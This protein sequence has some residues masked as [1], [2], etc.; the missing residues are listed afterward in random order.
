[1]E[2][3]ELEEQ[4]ILRLPLSEA[5]TIRETLRTKPKK[6]KKLLKIDLDVSRAA[7][8]VIVGRSKLYAYLKKFPTIIESYKTNIVGDKTNLYKTAD[9]SYML[10]CLAEPTKNFKTDLLHGYAPPL[11][12]VKKRRFRK[13]LVNPEMTEATELTTK[14]LYYLLNTDLEAMSTKFELIDDSNQC[15][16][17]RFE[18]CQIEKMLFRRVSTTD[19]DFEIEIPD[20][21]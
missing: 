10:E 21:H 6:I 5:A 9:V 7:G 13:N 12:N 15:E 2:D 3:A 19:S 16:V 20:M 8:T 4:F 18:N 11:K 1:M 14:E 17:T